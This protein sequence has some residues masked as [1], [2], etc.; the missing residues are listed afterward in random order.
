M[1]TSDVSA[2]RTRT[3]ATPRR[4]RTKSE[5]PLLT[6]EAHEE[7]STFSEEM[8]GTKSMTRR[9]LWPL[10]EA[11]FVGIGAVDW[12]LEKAVIIEKNL[13]D[14]GH[15]RNEM[16]G[17]VASQMSA[18]VGEKTKTMSKRGRARMKQMGEKMGEGMEKMTPKRSRVTVQPA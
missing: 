11:Y 9:A 14:R 7:T 12:M 2:Q 17:R 13:A 15:R 4:R 6:N 5:A 18:T 8:P 10:K 16:L 3:G 1:T